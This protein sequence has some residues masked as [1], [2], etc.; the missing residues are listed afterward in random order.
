MPVV[1]PA[2]SP[3]FAPSIGS[4]NLAGGFGMSGPIAE[5]D[6]AAF[7][8]QFQINLTTA[9]LSTRAFLPLVRA[10]QGA[11]VFFA[12]EAALEGARTSGM[13]AYVAAKSG[14]VA[15]MRSVADEGR[16]YGVRA[17]ALAPSSIRTATNE[18]SMGADAR[19]IEREDVASVVAF[20]SSPAA[21]AITGQ[22]IRLRK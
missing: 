3:T 4:P 9:Y 8:R 22:V 13:S 20:L 10:A 15:L 16:E 6:P 5:S 19:Y 14:V 1:T 18:A 2:T 11:V 12:S 17:N 21:A 7:D